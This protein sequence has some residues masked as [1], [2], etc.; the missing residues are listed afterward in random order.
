VST[1][2]AETLK[3]GFLNGL[4]VTVEMVKVIVPF[5]L[6]V[7]VARHFGIIKL[8]GGFFGPS[9]HLFGLPGEGAL[10]L[11]AGYTANMY[12][13]IAVLSPLHL[14]SRDVTTI[15]LMLGIAHSLTVETPITK[16]TGVSA[17]FML[18][19]RIVLSLLS[20]MALNLIWKLF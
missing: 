16:K 4:S 18:L 15:A 20:G 10:V 7:E 12:A 9:M 6:L 13:A 17:S 11:I 5:Y 3:K 1:S 8:I 19:V 14:S 2:T